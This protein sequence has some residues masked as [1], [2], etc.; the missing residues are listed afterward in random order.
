MQNIH[1]GSYKI[2]NDVEKNL[3]QAG[4]RIK[5]KCT[6]CGWYVNIPATEKE[7]AYA[8]AIYQKTGIWNGFC[9]FAG[10]PIGAINGC[11]YWC[12]KHDKKQM[13]DMWR[14]KHFMDNHKPVSLTIGER[15][16]EQGIYPKGYENVDFKSLVKYAMKK[17]KEK[18]NTTEKKRARRL[19]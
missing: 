10:K 17:E 15:M 11:T 18:Q 14:K 16:Q 4:N 8:M 5:P 9:R 3:Q 13:E 6:N 2:T 7:H 1:G 12:F 19:E